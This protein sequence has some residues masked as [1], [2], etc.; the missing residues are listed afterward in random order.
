MYLLSK[1]CTHV[2]ASYMHDCTLNLEAATAKKNCDSGA[3]GILGYDY[4]WVQKHFCLV[5][6][7]A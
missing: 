7:V 5:R 1:A 3:L 4:V 6:S 2:F